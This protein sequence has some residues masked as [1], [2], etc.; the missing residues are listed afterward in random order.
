MEQRLCALSDIEDGE[1][2]AFTIT[3]EDHPLELM[4]IRRGNKAFVY[5]NSCPHWGSPLDLCP[6]RFLN[7]DRTLVQCSTHGAQFR[8]EDGYCIRGPCL[9]ASLEYVPCIVREG[10]VVVAPDPAPRGLDRLIESTR[11]TGVDAPDGE[12]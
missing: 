9:G 6:G 11:R 4:A 5:I 3:V 1:S 7:R 12:A 8:I 2:A 10:E